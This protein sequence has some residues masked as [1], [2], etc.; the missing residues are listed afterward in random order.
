MSEKGH[1]QEV[2]VTDDQ[3]I[4]KRNHGDRQEDEERVDYFV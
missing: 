1:C 2:N 4:N 3:D